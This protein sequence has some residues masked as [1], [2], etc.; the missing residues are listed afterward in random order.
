MSAILT[1]QF[2]VTRASDFVASIGSTTKTHYAFLGMPLTDEVDLNWSLTIPDPIDDFDQEYSYSSNMI[3]LSKINPS[4]IRQVIPKYQWTSGQSYEMYRHDYNRNNLSPYTR[5]TRLYDARYYVVNRDYNVYICL[6]NGTDPENPNGRPS[7]NEPTHTSPIPQI[8]GDG[9]DRYIW[10]FLYRINPLDVIKFDST[11]FI[12]VPPDWKNNSDVADVRDF[13]INGS[14]EVV[15]IRNA[16]FG[17]GSANTY[18]NIPILGDGNGGRVSISVAADGR[19]SNAV[20]TNKGS[21]Y[22]FGTV[23]I[24]PFIPHTGIGT[25]TLAEF[26]VIVPPKGGHGKD[27]YR[28][29]GATRVLLYTRFENIVAENPDTIASN[30][31][32]RLGIVREPKIYGS[33]SNYTEGTGS[34]LYAIKLTGVGASTV[35]FVDDELVTQTVGVGSTAVGRVA[36]YDNT[37]QVLKIWQDRSL[38]LSQPKGGPLSNA[39]GIPPRYG[40]RKF[41]FTG[42]IGAG[43]SVLIAQPDNPSPLGLSIDTTFNGT[44]TVINSKTYKL[45]QNFVNGVAVPEIEPNSGDIIYIDNRDSIPRSQ[46]QKEDV[47]IIIEF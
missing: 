42:N 6:Q 10:K 36:S 28:E 30:S 20:V 18:N 38:Y 22:T 9:S 1:D 29:L 31:F 43:A 26:D 34:S 32:A 3:S 45:G 2:R 12:P 21:N 5:S 37:T 35:S 13:S 14:I 4:D 8:A 15:T 39:Y 17:Y 41:N 40:F 27:I 7:L 19:I 16:G 23:D 24:S 47:K 25:T 11:D 33:D 44:T 46:N